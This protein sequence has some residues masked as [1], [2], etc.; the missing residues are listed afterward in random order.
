[1]NASST[2]ELVE[3]LHRTRELLARPSS[4]FAWSH[5]VNQEDALREFDSLTLQ[6]EVGDSSR[7]RELE[8]LFAPTGSIQEVS[9]NS[10]WA[11]EFLELAD[12]FDSLIKRV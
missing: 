4:D 5:W 9:I 11:D 8:L 10:G 7:R 12:R 6:I 1:V 2:S 3:V